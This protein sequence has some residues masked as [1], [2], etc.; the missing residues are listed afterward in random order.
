MSNKKQL[1]TTKKKTVDNINYNKDFNGIF[2]FLC[3]NS[4]IKNDL[5]ITCSSIWEGKLENIYKF[6]NDNDFIGI[7]GKPKSWICFKFKNKQVILTDYTI[8]SYKKGFCNP[9]SWIIE[10]SNG[11]NKWEIIDKQID[12]TLF[13]KKLN[14][15]LVHTFQIDKVNQNPFQYLRITLT[16]SNWGGNN[17]LIINCFEIYG[18]II[19]FD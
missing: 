1:K 19:S 17:D 10:G 8:R 14:K 15:N 6:D 13:K 5:F 16:D 2:D 12:C 11:E 4:S 7:G 3:K 18:Q 9:K